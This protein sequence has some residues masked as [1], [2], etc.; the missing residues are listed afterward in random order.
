MTLKG[1]NK[2]VFWDE[3]F[4]NHGLCCPEGLVL[5]LVE[6]PVSDCANYCEVSTHRGRSGR[7]ALGSAAQ[8]PRSCTDRDGSFV[9]YWR[10]KF[11]LKNLVGHGHSKKLKS[12]ENILPRLVVLNLNSNNYSKWRMS[13]YFSLRVA[14]KMCLLIMVFLIRGNDSAN[15]SFILTISHC[16]RCLLC[17]WRMLAGPV[18]R[19]R[20]WFALFFY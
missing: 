7:D 2:R 13:R 18:S 3:H 10:A 1:R 11:T 15:P 19:W 16:T 9:L 6:F 17:A 20:A 8:E 14:I 4:S 5:E 12:P